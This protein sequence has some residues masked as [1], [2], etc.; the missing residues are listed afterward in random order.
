MSKVTA[1]FFCFKTDH[2][3]SLTLTKCCRWLNITLKK[4]NYAAVSTS[5][6]CVTRPDMPMEQTCLNPCFLCLSEFKKKWR[7]FFLHQTL[8]I[9]LCTCELHYLRMLDS[10][11]LFSTFFYPLHI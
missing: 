4:L 10:A 3:F 9:Q 7:R 2:D 8:V 5:G 11:F 6:Y 1:G